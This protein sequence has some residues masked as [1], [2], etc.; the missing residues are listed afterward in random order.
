MANYLKFPSKYLKIQ[1]T[2]TCKLLG[3]FVLRAGF[4]SMKE[5]DCP[6]GLMPLTSAS[7][8]SGQK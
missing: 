1:L 5:I 4:C 7:L 8:S 6:S 3:L 2:I